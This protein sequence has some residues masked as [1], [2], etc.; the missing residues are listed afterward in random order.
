MLRETEKEI[1]DG[2]SVSDSRR[3]LRFY[4][5]TTK[6]KYKMEALVIA[7]LATRAMY[8]QQDSSVPEPAEFQPFDLQALRFPRSYQGRQHRE[9]IARSEAAL[10]T[11]DRILNCPSIGQR[12]TPRFPPD[13]PPL[14]S[15]IIA[16][17]SNRPRSRIGSTPLV[18]FEDE[19]EFEHGYDEGS[20]AEFACSSCNLHSPILRLLNSC[21]S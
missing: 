11:P 9:A 21:N 13:D 10:C 6:G 20:N 18:E 14:I 12:R 8:R 15:P 4:R 2:V 16:L 19:D 1:P 7:L 5:S 3:S 17:S